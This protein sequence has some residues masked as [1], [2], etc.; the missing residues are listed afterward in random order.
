[1]FFLNAAA[2]LLKATESSAIASS[3]WIGSGNAHEADK[4]ATESMRQTLNQGDFSG[5]VV[6]GEGERDAAPML[7]IGERLGA[8]VNKSHI[9]ELA[10]AVDPLEGTDL[11][12]QAKGN[13][14][15][16]IAASEKGGLLNAPD[17]YMLKIAVG[18]TPKPVRLDLL[19]PIEDN[20]ITLAEVK[21]KKL[22]DISVML[23]DRPRHHEIIARIKA[24]GCKIRLIQD[25]DV[26]AVILTCLPEHGVDMYYGIGGAPEGVLAAAAMR[27][28]GGQMQ[29]QFIFRDTAEEERAKQ[30]GLSDPHHVYT[31]NQLAPGKD[32]IFVMSGVTDGVLLKGV[33]RIAAAPSGH[34]VQSLVLSTA[35][36][37][38]RWAQSFYAATE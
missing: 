19:A 4:A 24:L 10:V 18:S 11:C 31:T 29:G 21:G 2:T 35:E 9:P 3:A 17:I 15:S 6:I 14:L 8:L 16:V 1:M 13:A 37:N 38:I 12:A 36:P 25:G 20:I 27:C 28:L 22:E 7:Y 23:L 30:F 26:Q 34:K 5:T 32:I 33:H